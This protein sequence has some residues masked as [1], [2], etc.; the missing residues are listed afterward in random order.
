[1]CAQK[2][3]IQILGPK[4]WVLRLKFN[5]NI[6]ARTLATNIIKTFRYR[7]IPSPSSVKLKLN[8]TDDA[9]SL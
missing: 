7:L 2:L 1:L 5:K 4:R 9:I 8:L 6:K 3:S